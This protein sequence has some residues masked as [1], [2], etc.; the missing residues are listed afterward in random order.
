MVHRQVVE[1]R[2]VHSP[3]L[4]V[5]SANPQDRQQKG[6]GKPQSAAETIIA[7]NNSKE[8]REREEV[9]EKRGTHRSVS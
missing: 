8:K 3:L 9:V 7:E 2:C 6:S 4:L 5:S 1:C